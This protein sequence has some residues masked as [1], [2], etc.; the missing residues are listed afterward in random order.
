VG[1]SAAGAA[2]ET[3]AL[4]ADLHLADGG[5]RDPFCEDELFATTVGRL[6][7]DAADRRF[8]LVLLGDTV[9]FPAVTLPGAPVTP[10]TRPADAVAKLDRVLAAH[11]PVVTAL[12]ELVEAGHH[13][14]VVAGNHDM[15]LVMPAVQT[16]LRD[17]IGGRPDSVSVHPW[18]VY[19][20]GLLYA[21]HGQQQH[22]VN[23]FTRL[24]GCGCADEPLAVPAGSYLD[25]LVH[26]RDRQPGASTAALVAQAARMGAGLVGGLVRL[27]RAERDRSDR[28]RDLEA[29]VPT[30]LPP[31]AVLAIDRASAATPTSIARRAAAMAARRL[32]SSRSGPGIP[33]M[34]AAAQRVHQVLEAQECAVPFY[35]FGHTHIAEDVPLG[36]SAGARYL[37]PG[38]WSSMLRRAPG[39]ERRCGV[40]VVEREPGA[41]PR[42]ELRAPA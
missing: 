6:I 34:H 38:T 33:Y 22:D 39:G 29:S 12:Q 27:S 4:V 32:P 16:R 14:D 1:V 28:E 40:V 13:V 35:A 18:M 2:G 19:V 36:T 17:A 26:L 23:R 30:G 41:A 7:A 3:L 20:P 24:G 37:N 5:D 15:E 31:A 21:E 42:A 10:A 11:Q 9:D 25:A 8:R